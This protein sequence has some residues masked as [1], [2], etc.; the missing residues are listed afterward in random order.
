MSP[1]PFGREDL[2]ERTERTVSESKENKSLSRAEREEKRRKEERA[3]H[4]SIALYS[5][6]GVVVVVAALVMI[7]WNTGILQ[8]NITALEVDGVKYTAADVDFYFNSA[9]N[10]IVNQYTQTYYMAPFDT[11]SSTKNQVYDQESGQTWY[12]YLMETAINN[13]KSDTA[14]SAKAAAEGY[15]LSESAQESLDSTVK[16]METGWITS[17]YTSRDSFIKVNFGSAMTFD[18]LIELLNMQ[19]LAYDYTQSQLDA[20][21][22]PE[23]DYDAYYTENADSLDTYTLTQFVFQARVNTTDDEGNTIEMTDEEKSAALE[24]A[25]AEQKALAEELK[26]KLEAGED[27]QALAEEYEEQLY[28]SVLSRRTVGSSLAGYPYADWAMEEGRQAG[29]VTLSEYDAGTGTTYNYYVVRFEGRELD[30]SATYNVR[31]ILVAAEQDEGADEPTQEQYDAAYTKAEELL[32]EWKSGEAT[33]DS[34]AALATENSADAGSA[35]NGG[36]I[37]NITQYSTYVDTFMDWVLDPSRQPGDTGLVQNTG[38]STKGW[39]IMYFVS[40]GDP[41]WR[42]T[43]ATALRNQD[44]ERLIADATDG[45]SVTE[46]IGMKLVSGK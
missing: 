25:K 11:S 46:S 5:L 26:A 22:H 33:E 19:V 37:S 18:R 39:H 6:V 17:G 10:S 30:Q 3:N 29:D 34:F 20:I 41:I 43:A 28:S 12:D 16:Q 36:L 32:N 2:N 31:H 38:S 35:S 13:L 27:P 21:D 44:Y 14:L 15:T 9:Y 1:G 42:Q 7:L 40:S 24:E 8:R 45:L 4:R 23:S